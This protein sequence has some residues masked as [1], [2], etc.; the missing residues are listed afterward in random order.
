MNLAPPIIEPLPDFISELLREQKSLTAVERFS[1]LHDRGAL[2]ESAEP[3][4]AKYYRR[5]LPAS[6]P[7]PGQQFAFQVDLDKCSGCK[8]CVV[9]CHTMNGLEEGEVWRR[10]GTVLA[11]TQQAGIQHVTTA[12]HH[13]LDPGCLNGCPVKAYEKDP[14]TGIVRH[15]DDQCIG[16]KYCTMMCPYDV[17]KYNERLGIVRKCDMCHQRL[18]I[19][20]APA[21][22]QACPNEAIAITLVS[23]QAK[24]DDENRL[25]PGAPLSGITQ[26]TTVFQTSREA[27]FL[28]S[29]PQDFEI[30]EVA[31]SHWPLAALLVTTQA[32]VGLIAFERIS[33]LTAWGLGQSW[34]PSV[35]LAAGMLALLVAGVG[36][37]LGALHLGQPLRAWRVFL[38]LRT[39]WLSREAIVLGKYVGLLAAAVTMLL[40]SVY[41]DTTPQ[42]LV[43]LSDRWVPGWLPSAMTSVALLAGATGLYC[44]A[45][46]YVVTRRALWR[47][48]RTFAAFGGSTLIGGL[49]LFVPLLLWFESSKFA[50][51]FAATTQ[52]VTIAV[53]IAWEF[54]LRAS[55]SMR[56]DAYDVRSRRLWAGTLKRWSALRFLM[57]LT[58]MALMGFALTGMALAAIAI[59]LDSG[60]ARML[61]LAASSIAA[62]LI[63]AGELMERLIYFAS[64]VY[65][66][67]PGTMR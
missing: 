31:D 26:P 40:V 17:P 58:G 37:N 28:S 24:C 38:G 53:K 21:C 62:M 42:A 33:A 67:M 50:I 7:G 36:M 39:S 32:S 65:D 11:T 54:Q 30:D 4:Q 12:C 49:A 3:A 6:P 43:D 60:Q 10:V 61:A 15:L 25:A 27:A 19:G 45:M 18:S 1:S 55:M 14:E 34:S 41:R 13:C 29:I 8:A 2:A 56:G 48:S 5:L 51:A 46:I 52:F 35:S 23:T 64:V 63:L 47:A 57:A 59:G 66:R 9:A 20:E 44:S 22:V 16:C